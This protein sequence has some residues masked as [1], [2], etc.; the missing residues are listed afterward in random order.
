MA[1]TSQP[2]PTSHQPIAGPEPFGIEV[3]ARKPEVVVKLRG[4]LD[5]GTAPELARTLAELGSQSAEIRRIVVDLRELSFM[6][7]SGVRVLEDHGDVGRDLGLDLAVVP[8]QG[9][10]RYVLEL[11]RADQRLSLVGDAELAVGAP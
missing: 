6:D 10:A 4:E 11:T 7:S 3:H 9:A 5:F 1:T 2:Q 8:G